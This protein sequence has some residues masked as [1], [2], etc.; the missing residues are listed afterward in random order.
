MYDIGSRGSLEN[1][2]NNILKDNTGSGNRP[3]KFFN[4]QVFLQ[5]EIF[6]G[7]ILCNADNSYINNVT[8][9][10]SESFKNSGMFVFQTDNSNFTNINSSNN[11]FGISFKNSSNNKIVNNTANSNNGGGISLSGSSNSN[12]LM[13]NTINS[14]DV[15]FGLSSSS[16]NTLTG[17]I[18]TNNNIGIYS[19]KSNSTINSNYVCGSVDSDF[20]SD[21]WQSSSGDNNIC[22]YHEG[23]SDQGVRGC[24]NQC[25]P[26]Y[27]DDGAGTCTIR[28][29]SHCRCINKALNDNTNCYRGVNLNGSIINWRWRSCINNPAN[30]SNK[31]FD[32]RGFMIDGDNISPPYNAGIYLNE[33]A[34][35]TIRNC[36]I[37]G[38]E[39]GIDLEYSPA[40]N[41]I[42]NTA[43][44]ND[45]FGI[46]LESSSNNSVIN[47][48][49]SLNDYCGI[50]LKDS[51]NN[52][53]INNKADLNDNYG[54]YLE[55]SSNNTLKN[56][57]VKENNK[58]DVWVEEDSDTQCNNI[59][60][61]NTGSGDRPIKFFNSQVNLQNEFLSELILCNADNSSINNV[62]IIGSESLKNN[63]MFVFQTD[64]SNFT[65]INSSNNYRGIYLWFSSNNTLMSNTAN[66]NSNGGVYSDYSSSNTFGDN[67]AN[68]NNEWG[69][70]LSGS[71]N[72][73]LGNNTANLNDYG[74]YLWRNSNF[75]NISNNKILNNT[76]G[77]TISDCSIPGYL[78]HWGRWRIWCPVGN[79]NNTLE[80]NVISDNN[81]GIYSKNSSSI[82]NSNTVCG[83]SHL[84]FNSS[85]WLNS[86]G[87]NNTC[88]NPDGWNDTG[89]TGCTHKCSHIK[90][91]P[92]T[93]TL[94]SAENETPSIPAETP[95]ENKTSG[96]LIIAAVIIILIIFLLFFLLRKK[97]K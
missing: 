49:V 43:S 69:I 19:Q 31:V 83:N 68:S 44:L 39:Y 53:V 73:I 95:L 46:Y 62:T 55:S 15:G 6:S 33:K 78:D 52:S 38:F 41:I 20:N 91:K 9:I 77:I 79:V 50:Y 75:N 58:F 13:A 37:T 24:K 11:R 36:I 42:N 82:V 27:V 10:G 96:S 5:D 74:I 47:N 40:N 93:E 21:D 23:W 60:E 22:K 16:N 2:C 81:I 67:T 14:N 92:S 32:C 34:N 59:I 76:W 63:G 3:I 57:T 54:I 4:S 48:N 17:N 72:N 85:N 71:S 84:D 8:I 87:T 66:N 1:L 80:G 97:L 89:K 70:H 45:G 94:P 35:N 56:N 18:I 51:S 64:N 61:N 26:C 7:L 65:N 28:T 88:N 86:S 25:P 12:T 30:F 29:G 90:I